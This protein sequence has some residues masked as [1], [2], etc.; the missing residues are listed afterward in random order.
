MSE[1]SMKRVLI[2]DDSELDSKLLA[3]CLEKE[4]ETDCC[5]TGEQALKQLK[6]EKFDLLILDVNLPGM[7]GFDVLRKV[8]S[9]ARKEYLGIVVLTANSDP[10][11]TELALNLGADGFGVKGDA[12]H[13]I[14]PLARSAIRV[15]SMTDE[16]RDLNRKLKKANGKLKKLS[17]TDHLTGLFNMRYINQRTRQGPCASV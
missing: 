9:R 6:Q 10:E 8:R 17:I 11:T 13:Q 16:L 7:S 14:L 15:K 1:N 4:F 12:V 3:K 5:S 2:V